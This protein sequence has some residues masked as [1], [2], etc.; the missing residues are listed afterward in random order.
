MENYANCKTN[1]EFK[2]AKVIAAEQ[3]IIQ[4][5]TNS[6]ATQ[7]CLF[8]ENR[9]AV[10]AVHNE[11]TYMRAIVGLLNSFPQP[12]RRIVDGNGTSSMARGGES[13]EGSSSDGIYWYDI[14]V[15]KF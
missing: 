12:S 5:Q 14:L 9:D 15:I 4:Q 10:I 6:V 7:I 1:W 3:H 11:E 8:N 13:S 2:H